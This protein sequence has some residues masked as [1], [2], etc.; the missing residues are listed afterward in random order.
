MDDVTE[1]PVPVDDGACDHLPGLAMPAV[2]LPSTAGRLVDLGALT[3]PRTVIYCYPR[4][5]GAG[6]VVPR[7]LGSDPGR[8]GLRAAVL[9][10]SQPPPGVRRLGR[11]GGRPQHRDHRLPARDGRTPASAIRGPERRRL[12]SLIDAL[13]LPTFGAS[14]MRLIKRLTLIV[15]IR[16]SVARFRPPSCRGRQQNLRIGVSNRIGWHL[17][18][19]CDAGFQCGMTVDG[20]RP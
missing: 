10:V 17:K 3:A 19:L 18:D 2:R 13:R 16:C 8:P 11:R 12:R 9:R 15:R 5:G 6:T 20:I 7:R 14:Q 1:L 4:T